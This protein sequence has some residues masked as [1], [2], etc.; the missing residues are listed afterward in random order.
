MKNFKNAF[1]PILWA[2]VTI[3]EMILVAFLALTDL[4][5]LNLLVALILL[6][7]LIAVLNGLLLLTP[8]RKNRKNAWKRVAGYLLSSVLV[9]TSV[10][11]VYYLNRTKSAIDTVTTQSNIVATMGVYTLADNSAE[12]IKDLADKTFGFLET[13]DAERNATAASEINEKSGGE[14]TKENF[15][16]IYELAGAL[17]AGDAD[18][19]V[20]D[21]AYVSLLTETEIEAEA[22]EGE[23][24]VEVATL[25]NYS[26]FGERTKLVYEVQIYGEASE[27]DE[28][29]SDKN[30]TG[31]PF[32]IYVS[33]SDTRSTKL[34]TSRSDVNIIVEVNPTTHEIIMINTPRDYY[35]GNPAGG[36]TKDK[37]THLGIYGIENSMEGLS[38]LY[39]V[40]ADHYVQINFTGFEQ[41]IDNLGGITVESLYSFT[42]TRYGGPFTYTTGMNTL[43]ADAALAFCRDRFEVPGGDVTRGLHQMNVIKA[44]VA[45]VTSSETLLTNYDGLM[46]GLEGTFTT[47]FTSEEISDLVKMQ[48]EDN[49]QWNIHSFSVQGTGGKETTYS[50]PSTACYVMLPDESMVSFAKELLQKVADGEILSDEDVVYQ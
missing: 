31:E 13:Y 18:A 22:E 49:I 24:S 11:G 47:N 20:L 10:A 12:D 34:T 4:L 9:L 44:L 17:Y 32:I 7:I 21:E 43:S 26:D 25:P 29:V 39:D 45:K 33:G 19:V 23:E 5:P 42:S 38:Q 40:D 50:T 37:L 6:L 15:S 8:V 1:P 48:L 30:I 46:S 41:L 35:I 36:G 28:E 14:L 2:V 27:E 16:S 3:A